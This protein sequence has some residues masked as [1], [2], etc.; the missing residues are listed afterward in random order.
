M[1]IRTVIKGQQRKWVLMKGVKD[2]VPTESEPGAVYALGCL[3]CNCIYLGETGQ[4][5]KKRTEEHW[6]HTKKGAGEMSAVA[7]HVITTGHTMFW[8]P[9]V[10]A[11]EVNTRGR[12][13]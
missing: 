6:N 2:K 10:I 9:R 4:S 1:S 8:K 11:R 13:R 5:A 3:D 7:N 12:G